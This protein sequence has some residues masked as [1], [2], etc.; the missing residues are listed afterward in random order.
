MCNAEAITNFNTADLSYR[1]RVKTPQAWG[2]FDLIMSFVEDEKPSRF[3]PSWHRHCLFSICET[4]RVTSIL[5]RGGLMNEQTVK[6]KWREIKGEIQKIWGD[7]TG[8]DLDKTDGNM[9]SV[10]GMIQQKYGTGRDEI[11]R[12]LDE[13]V[14]RFGADAADKSE[15][16]KQK[17]KTKM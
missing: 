10:A 2:F 7:I 4:N 13:I 16:L 11:S 3:A 1:L 12:K 14:N 5:T 6:G 17:M 9:K 15:T 8:D